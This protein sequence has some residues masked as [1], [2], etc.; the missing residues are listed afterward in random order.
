MSSPSDSAQAKV[1]TLNASLIYKLMMEKCVIVMLEFKR[2]FIRSNLLQTNQ[3]HLLLVRL[4]W[5]DFEWRE[6]V[7]C[8][9][10][11]DVRF[12]WNDFQ[13]ENYRWLKLTMISGGTPTIEYATSRASGV[14][15]F[16]KRGKRKR[17]IEREIKMIKN[18]K[19]IDFKYLWPTLLRPIE[20]MLHHHKYPE[21]R[22]VWFSWKMK[23]YHHWS[24]LTDAFPAVTTPSFLNTG[25]NLAR[26]S[27]VAWGLLDIQ[28]MKLSKLLYW[29]SEPVCSKQE[30]SQMSSQCINVSLTLKK[31][32]TYANHFTYFG[33]SSTAKSTV[34]PLIL[35]GKGAISVLKTPWSLA[36]FH[37]FWER[38]ANSST[39]SRVIL[40]LTARFSAVIAIGDLQ[41]ESVNP[42]QRES[43]N[44][45]G[46]PRDVPKRILRTTNGASD[47]L[48][49][50]PVRDI[51]AAP[52]IMSCAK[53]N[54][55]IK[56]IH[57]FRIDS[58][59]ITMY[60]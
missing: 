10:I 40:C 54:I 16:S 48:S 33:C 23:G 26:P 9:K 57:E 55:Q 31:V 24:L 43:S 11:G 45:F 38:N 5:E 20:R 17:Y 7:Q 32:V 46:T 49:I 53:K 6:Q 35:T 18:L 41:Y 44:T 4:L 50:P 22:S 30:I 12:S 36:A 56:T 14:R 3:C 52:K 58:C 39:F 13:M 25:F 47:I 42:D 27:N 60:F 2:I 21:I 1:C 37:S 19:K 8:P 15:L 29:N 51:F 34:L 59:F 28:V